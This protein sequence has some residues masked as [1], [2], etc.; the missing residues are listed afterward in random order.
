MATSRCSGCGCILP[1]GYLPCEGSERHER[2]V[3]ERCSHCASSPGDEADL[4]ARVKELEGRNT[5]LAQLA[6][7]GRVEGK[8]SGLVHRALHDQLVGDL[9]SKLA[10]AEAERD[11]WE[12][13]AKVRQS[14]V[15]EALNE[16]ERLKADA[17][18]SDRIRYPDEK[19]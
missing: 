11:E 17:E 4:R 9:R 13:I 18:L 12:K 3:P 10:A 15:T 2:A 7:R 16:V 5:E 14:E 1:S 19:G 6:E 8:P